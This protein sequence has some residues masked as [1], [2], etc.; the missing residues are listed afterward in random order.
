MILTLLSMLGGG[1]MR[2]L[3]EVISFMNKKTDNKHEL[4]MMDKQLELQRSKSADDR[5]TMQVAGD[6]ATTIALMDAQKEALKS[7]MQLTNVWWVD[8]L[9]FLVRPLTTY[10]FLLLYGAS[11]I[12]MFVTAIYGDVTGWEA[13]LKIYDP[14]DR[15]ILSAILSFWFVGRVIDKK[16]NS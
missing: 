16:P 3:P 15:A 9:N 6:I 7:Q 14:E 5:A 2:L 13:I 4:D 8:A 12:A 11:K 1:L 10:Y